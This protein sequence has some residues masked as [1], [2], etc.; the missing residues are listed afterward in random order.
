VLGRVI[1]R[2][3]CGRG[4]GIEDAGGEGEKGKGEEREPM[5]GFFTILSLPSRGENLSFL[6]WILRGSTPGG[7]EGLLIF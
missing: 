1:K 7:T 6:G 2:E 4:R 5:G 3:R